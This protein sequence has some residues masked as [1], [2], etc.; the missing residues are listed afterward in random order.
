M[1]DQ[2]DFCNSP[3]LSEVASGPG[4]LPGGREGCGCPW[5]LLLLNSQ[6]TGQL[7]QPSPRAPICLSQYLSTL[8]SWQPVCQGWIWPSSLYGLP[9][10]STACLSTH[11]GVFEVGSILSPF[12]IGPGSF[13][14]AATEKASPSW[15]QT[16]LCSGP[17]VLMRPVCVYLH[18]HTAA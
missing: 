15:P 17:R 9:F 12:P 16:E 7:R 2:D 6:V 5:P 10:I 13:M 11:E 4:E 8:L 18:A 1:G 3:G 14:A